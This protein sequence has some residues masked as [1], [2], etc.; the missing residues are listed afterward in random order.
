MKRFNGFLATILAGFLLAALPASAA[1]RL[2]TGLQN[3]MAGINTTLVTNGV[4]TT[5]TD[6]PASWTA[7]TATLTSEGAAQGGSGY[8]MRVAESGGA[9]AGEAY[10]DITTKIGHY[11]RLTVYFKKGTADSGRVLIGTTGDNDAILASAA[12]SDAAWAL[13]TFL[14]EATA[15]TTRI[16]LES[17][18]ATAGEYSDFDT[19]ILACVDGSIQAALK[20]GQFMIYTGSQPADPD[21]APTG[22]LLVTVKNGSSGVTFGDAVDGY[23]S[24]TVGESW[25]GVGVASGTA[26][27]F[28]LVA[29]GDLGT[30]NETD[31]RLDGAVSTSSGELNFSSLVFTV[32]ATQTISDFH[33]TV[34]MQ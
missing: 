11:Y 24:K 16:T 33:P 18:D 6:P 27:W 32:G 34:N 26:G 21:D 2:S 19:I 13:K 3:Q 28:R 22:T 29:P 23:L 25:T 9:A 1:M 31:C 30:D 4:F 15:T 7:V 12:L 17:T 14:F 20:Y 10:Q 8:C 5:D